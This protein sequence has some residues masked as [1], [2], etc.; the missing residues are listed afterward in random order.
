MTR[1]HKTLGL[2]ACLS[3]F[4]E[5]CLARGQAD[6]T[7]DGKEVLCLRFFDWCTHQGVHSEHDIDLALLEAYRRFLYKYR[8][9]R[10]AM[11]LA[12]STQRA[13]LMAVTSFLK[14]LYYHE[15]IAS[16][17][18]TKFRL[19]RVRK[20]LPKTI[21]DVEQIEQLIRQTM[22]KGAIGLRDRAILELF[23][24]S[25]PRRAELA[26]L[27]I[28]D[29]D[30]KRG[31]VTIHKGKGD[32]DRV[33]P[34]G[35][36]ALFWIKSYLDKLRPLHARLDSGEALFLGTTG[37]RIRKST[38]TDL[39]HEYILRSAVA[40]KGS[41]HLLRHTTPTHMHRNGA[42]LRDLQEF[43]GHEDPKTTEIYTHVTIRDL[44][45]TYK[46]THPFEIDHYV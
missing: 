41:C 7:V 45:R 15:M 46:S 27:D 21:P 30:F 32:Q 39:V 23:Y 28:R 22:T 31:T 29:I 4:L 11:P 34:V 37:K 26:N 12:L 40:D 25:A 38:L 13:R 42:E 6:A 18:Y 35:E 19:P 44:K 5:D 10:T 33:V 9:A 16:D 24:A 17:F 36:R 20:R 14:C 2:Q 43:L 1:K 3:F 8:K